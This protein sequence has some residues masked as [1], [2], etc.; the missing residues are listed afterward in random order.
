MH[1]KL[2]YEEFEF[3]YS[4]SFSIS[5]SRSYTGKEHFFSCR[6][7]LSELGR[8]EDTTSG[9]HMFSGAVKTAFRTESKRNVTYV[10]HKLWMVPGCR[11]CAV[12]QLKPTADTE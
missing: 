10:T 9:V 4:H 12:W 3:E 7:F 11:S 1:L 6:S 8:V 5:C 2:G